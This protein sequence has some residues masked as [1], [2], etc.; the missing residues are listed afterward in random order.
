M[1]SML[2]LETCAG[3]PLAR[4]RG[5]VRLAATDAAKRQSHARRLVLIL[6]LDTSGS[7]SG[8]PV[9][10]L[11]T[12]VAYMADRLADPTVAKVMWRHTSEGM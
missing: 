8:A 1:D 4:I 6:V 5:H 3:V 2:P 11:N 12:A 9:R 7:M 10:Q